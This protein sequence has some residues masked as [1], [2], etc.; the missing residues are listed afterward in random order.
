MDPDTGFPELEHGSYVQAAKYG[1]IYYPF[2]S[3]CQNA[4]LKQQTWLYWENSI[5]EILEEGLAV[6]LEP[7]LGQHSFS[8]YTKSKWF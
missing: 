2:C 7:P 4:Q 8:L 1:S 6:H 5:S 3:S